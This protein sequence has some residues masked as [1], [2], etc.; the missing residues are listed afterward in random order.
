MRHLYFLVA[1][2][3][4]AQ[5]SFAQ[6]ITTSNGLT[7][8]G[9]DIRLGQNNRNPSGNAALDRNR[10]IPTNDYS[11]ILTDVLTSRSASLGGRLISQVDSTINKSSSLIPG[12]IGFAGTGGSGVYSNWGFD[13]FHVASGFLVSQIRSQVSEESTFLEL[14]DQINSN[15]KIRLAVASG[16]QDAVIENNNSVLSLSNG[17]DNMRFALDFN[18]GRARI[19]NG[20]IDPD[21]SQQFFQVYGSAFI[22]DS[23]ILPLIPEGS[24]NDSLVMWDANTKTLRRIDANRMPSNTLQRVGVSDANYT[25]TSSNYLIGF[26][27][28]STGRT[29]TLPAA[30]TMNNKTIIVKD[31]SGSAG[32]HNITVEGAGSETIDGAAAKTISTNF[33][34][35]TMYSN[36]VNWFVI[37]H[38]EN[39]IL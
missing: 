30:S 9:N 6:T 18:T 22:L 39:V 37:S 23:L 12:E 10:F 2:L 8:V 26:T 35:I 38:S 25:A 28:L 3:C 31:E 14:T 4:A 27:S 32:A 36:G 34:S 24:V 13:M 33:G 17:P 7:R 5:V 1:M 20:F 16:G 19:A 29:V 15:P 21:T 11:I